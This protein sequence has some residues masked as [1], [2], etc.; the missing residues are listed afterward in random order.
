MLWS[1]ALVADRGRSSGSGCSL[2]EAGE[3]GWWRALPLRLNDGVP[4][5]DDAREDE[6]EMGMGMGEVD[7]EEELTV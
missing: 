7:E 5:R 4:A 1:L 3:Y 2:K 6:A